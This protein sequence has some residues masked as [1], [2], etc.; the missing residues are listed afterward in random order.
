MTLVGTS[1][2][3]VDEV[4]NTG[5]DRIVEGSVDHTGTTFTVTFTFG[6][7]VNA[8]RRVIQDISLYA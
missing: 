4:L 8:C 5:I 3:D 7:F 2:I 6:T 1:T